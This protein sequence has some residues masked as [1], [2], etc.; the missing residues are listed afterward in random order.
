M[1]YFDPDTQLV[2]ESASNPVYRYHTHWDQIEG[3]Y[4][5]PDYYQDPVTAKE[6]LGLSDVDFDQVNSA[7]YCAVGSIETTPDGRI[8]DLDSC[9][10]TDNALSYRTVDSTSDMPGGGLE[11]ELKPLGD[12][13][14]LVTVDDDLKFHEDDYYS[15]NNP[16]NPEN[17]MIDDLIGQEL[18]DVQ[19]SDVEDE[20][21]S[22]IGIEDDVYD[23]NGDDSQW[24]WNLSDTDVQ[25]IDMELDDDLYALQAADVQNDYDELLDVADDDGR[26]CRSMAEEGNSY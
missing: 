8:I 18:Y 16:Y 21:S 6:N 7:Q 5:T 26:D 13:N 1:Y 20:Y 19:K 17:D 25:G 23:V 22:L 24:Q 11:L 2:E 4:V 15:I 12:F 14:S 10:P 9:V 3:G